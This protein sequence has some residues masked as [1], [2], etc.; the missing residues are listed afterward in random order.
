MEAIYSRDTI[1]IRGLQSNM[2]SRNIWMSTT[3]ELDRNSREACNIQQGR[4]QQ[5]QWMHE[6]TEFTKKIDLKSVSGVGS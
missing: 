3:A 5:Q 4:Q 6:S 2:D 1:G